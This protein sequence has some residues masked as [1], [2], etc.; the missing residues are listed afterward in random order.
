VLDLILYSG[1][2]PDESVASYMKLRE[3][4]SV[5]DGCVLRGNQVIIPKQGQQQVME[6]LHE[7]HSGNNRMKGLAQSC[8]WWPGI[9]KMIEEKVASCDTCQKYRHSPPPAPLHPWEFLRGPWEH[10]HT[11]IAG[12]LMGKMFLLVID[13]FSKWLEVKPLTTANSIN[14]IEHLRSIFST[15][16]LPKMLVTDNGSQ[17]TSAEFETFMQSNGIHHVKSVPYHPASN[18][19]A[20]RAVQVFK[21]GM[22]RQLPTDTLETRISKFLMWYRR[23]PHSTTGVPPAEVLLG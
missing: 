2:S 10:L 5:Q 12:P 22:K 11:D 6:V 8:V 7:S 3:E 13:A 20:E 21:E 23:T 19:L 14:T 1:S 17:F 15:H 16:G 9:D 4:L 18:G